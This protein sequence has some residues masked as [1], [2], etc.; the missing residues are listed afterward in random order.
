L[1]L[2]SKG[3]LRELQ[4]GGCGVESGCTRKATE[5]YVRHRIVAFEGLSALDGHGGLQGM[6]NPTGAICVVSFSVVVNTKPFPDI[7]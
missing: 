6:V 2:A 5:L 4:L 7:I 3:E 1:S